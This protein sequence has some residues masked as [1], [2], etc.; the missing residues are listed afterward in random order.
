MRVCEAAI[1]DTQA[2][3]GQ[4]SLEAGYDVGIGDELVVRAK[5]GGGLASVEATSCVTGEFGQL[6]CEGGKDARFAL[7]PGAIF[8]YVG[9]NF[10]LTWDVRYEL[11]AVKTGAQGVLFFLGFGF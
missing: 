5:V 8:V 4:F 7:L 2:S 11:I 3:L 9:Q 6:V 1:R 10:S